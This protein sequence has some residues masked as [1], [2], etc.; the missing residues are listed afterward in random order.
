MPPPAFR[1]R[2]E[3]RIQTHL[4]TLPT[5]LF[6]DFFSLLTF[7]YP[8]LPF[9]FFFI[10]CATITLLTSLLPRTSCCSCLLSW[11]ATSRNQNPPPASLPLPNCSDRT[12]AGLFHY[13]SSINPSSSGLV[14]VSEPVA[15]FN[16]SVPSPSFP[17]GATAKQ[18]SKHACLDLDLDIHL[19]HRRS[20]NNLA[21]RTHPSTTTNHTCTCTRPFDPR[22][23]P[24]AWYQVTCACL[25]TLL[26][27]GVVLLPLC[28]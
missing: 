3:V 8:L 21:I 22:S 25:H 5:Q 9:F 26:H 14:S 4:T 23:T 10:L 2:S 18:A 13:S 6:P 1:Y 12:T 20:P 17:L 15:L 16:H 19:A 11:G 7:F 27:Y 28:M 24:V